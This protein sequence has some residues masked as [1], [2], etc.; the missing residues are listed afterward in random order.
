MKNRQTRG[1]D[2][3]EMGQEQG[4]DMESRFSVMSHGRVIK[5][6]RKSDTAGVYGTYRVV[7]D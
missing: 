7:V 1:K 6:V 3:V 2:G 4:G 5:I